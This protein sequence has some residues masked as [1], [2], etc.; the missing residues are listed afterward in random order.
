MT[1]RDRR[2][3]TCYE[4]HGIATHITPYEPVSAKQLSLF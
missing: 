1:M 3:A 4:R 2:R